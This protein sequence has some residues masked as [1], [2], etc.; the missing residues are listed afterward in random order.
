MSA[1]PETPAP[2]LVTL[3]YTGVWKT[4]DGELCHGYDRLTNVTE[5]DDRTASG[6]RDSKQWLFSKK[7]NFAQ[8][9]AVFTMEKTPGKEGSVRMKTDKFIGLWHDS[10]QRATMQARSRAVEDAHAEERAV[11]KAGKSR[12][13]RELLEPLRD[14]YVQLNTAGRRQ[15]LADVLRYITGGKA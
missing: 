14:A 7:L 2:E 15:L 6:E 3:L 1:T 9:G 13:D 5:G 8:P 12:A 10:K 4:E 11:D